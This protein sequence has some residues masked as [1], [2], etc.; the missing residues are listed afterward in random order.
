[1]ALR[2]VANGM[3]DQ[4]L[5]GHFYCVHYAIGNGDE[6]IGFDPFKLDPEIVEE[7]GLPEI[8]AG[9]QAVLNNIGLVDLPGRERGDFKQYLQELQSRL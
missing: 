5:S 9:V 6:P 4:Q 1:M 2:R 7:Q 8:K 3:S